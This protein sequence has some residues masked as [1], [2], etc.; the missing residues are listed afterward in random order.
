MTTDKP[1]C[2][3]CRI[4]VRQTKQGILER[5]QAQR[6]KEARLACLDCGTTYTDCQNAWK[7]G[8][9]SGCCP[10]CRHI[11]RAKEGRMKG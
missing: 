2:E 11:E 5:Q 10:D 4:I 6:A 3:W 1:L 9:G 8:Y 7:Q